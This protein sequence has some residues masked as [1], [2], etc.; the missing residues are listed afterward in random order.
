MN[1]TM[2]KNDLQADASFLEA[3]D[4]PLVDLHKSN[5]LKLEID[6][7]LDEC[8]LDVQEISWATNAK[9]YVALLSSVLSKLPQT[10]VKK[11]GCPFTLRSEKVTSVEMPQDLTI[12][13]TGSYAVNCLTKKSGNA[14]VLPTLDC[15]IVVPDSYWHAKDY[16]NHRYMDVSTRTARNLQSN[17]RFRFS[18]LQTFCSALLDRNEISFFGV[19]QS[20]FRERSSKNMSEQ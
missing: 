18:R 4:E 3:V 11:D 19:L 17:C 5:I 13:P 9:D 15:A 16:L 20:C 14:N 8:R 12:V 10:P 7:L 2:S 6:E 1:T